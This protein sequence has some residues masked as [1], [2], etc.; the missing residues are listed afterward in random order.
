MI[1][2]FHIF[3]INN[4]L[5]IVLFNSDNKVLNKIGNIIVLSV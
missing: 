3:F 2:K 4:I 5:L 1:S